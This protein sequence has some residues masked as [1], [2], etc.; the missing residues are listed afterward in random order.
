[1]RVPPLHRPRPGRGPLGHRLGRRFGHRCVASMPPTLPTGCDNQAEW[2]PMGPL[3]LLAAITYDPIVHIELGPLKISPHGVGIAV[4][5]LLGARLM[6]PDGQ[7]QGHHRGRRLRP[8]DPGGHR[9]HH[10]RPRRLRHQPLRRL[11]RPARRLQDLGGR[12]LA[13]RRLLRRHPPR[14]ARDAQA[15]ALVLEG[16]G[17]RRAG[18]GPR[19]AHRPHRRP[20]R[21][22]PPGQAHDFF[23]G[24]K[25]PPPTVDTA[26]PCARRRR[27]PARAVRLLA[28]A[29]LL[30]ALLRLRRTPRYDGFLIIVFG[31]WY[32]VQPGHRGLP[33]R[34][35]AAPGPD[36]QPVDRHH[37]HRGVRLAPGVRAQDASVGQLGGAAYDGRAP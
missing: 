31:A 7:A 2:R 11:R 33:A 20:D 26:S 28:V 14:P 6:L 27:P 10:R 25:C 36:R 15:E 24:Y 32:G 19:R 13:A 37:H 1:M 16:D 3:D 30:V 17:R 5:F 34:G 18:H 21:R 9:R 12:H 4:G 29:I 23:L 35:R 8:A 22:R